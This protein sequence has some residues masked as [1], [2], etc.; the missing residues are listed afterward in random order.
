[1]ALH[2]YGFG[3][4]GSRRPIL[5]SET[6]K[7]EPYNLNVNRGLPPTPIGNPGLAS[8]KAAA[9]PSSKHY[10][11]YVRKCGNSGE[12]AFSITNAQFDKNVATYRACHKG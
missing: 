3:L 4:R 1:M 6:E 7:E 8:I 10:L 12:H 2:F 11:F 9:K 5:E